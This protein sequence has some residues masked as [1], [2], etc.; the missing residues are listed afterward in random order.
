MIQT[1]V[2]DPS[3]V[4]IVPGCDMAQAEMLELPV[5]LVAADMRDDLLVLTRA[6]QMVAPGV[7]SAQTIGIMVLSKAGQAVAEAVS[8]VWE[9]A[10]GQAAPPFLGLFGRAGEQSVALGGVA[11]FYRVRLEEFVRYNAQLLD[12]MAVL[13]IE[14]VDLS[15]TLRQTESF[16][17]K[18]VNSTRWLAQAYGPL[19]HDTEGQFK[20]A[21]GD[22]L[23]QRL[24]ASSAGLTDIGLF[25]PDQEIPATGCLQVQLYL[26]EDGPQVGEWKISADLLMAGWMRFSLVRALD[27]DEQTAWVELS[28]QGDEPLFLGAGLHHP[29]PE[30][31]AKLEDVGTERLLSH[32]IWKYLPGVKAPLSVDGHWAISLE[33][34]RFYVDAEHLAR[35]VP[36]GVDTTC[37]EYFKALGALQVHPRQQGVSAALLP[38]AVASGVVEISATIGNRSELGSHIEYALAVAPRHPV[39]ETGDLV[40]AC[41]R[42]GH[43]SDW[44]R[45]SGDR[46]GEIAL[47]LT[48]PPN[49]TCDLVLLTR[50]APG[51]YP[52]YGWATFSNIWMSG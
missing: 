2:S 19:R 3:F 44:V 10:T 28:W 37:L 6:D 17:L 5:D 15:R 49:Q 29:D 50:L 25:L 16:L 21:P 31:C 8:G 7:L 51:G 32:R 52:A 45:L 34:G 23:R 35:A 43:L 40:A 41:E 22:R 42:N 47:R 13:R 33:G 11:Q 39:R 1:E 26:V 36:A 4:L 27:D 9:G 18:S 38:G 12:M 48:A 46:K 14:H 24:S 30:F 20:L